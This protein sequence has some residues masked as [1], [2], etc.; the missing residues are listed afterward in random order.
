ME[1]FSILLRYTLTVP[2]S[3]QQNGVVERKNRII[4]DM[5]CIMLKTKNMPQ[6]FL[7]E[8]VDCT[9]YLSVEV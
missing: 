4:L 8:A 1:L 6:E 2:Y 3:P 7:V 5:A 9:V